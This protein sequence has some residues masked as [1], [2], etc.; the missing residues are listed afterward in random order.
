MPIDEKRRLA[1]DVID[2]S[3]TIEETERQVDALVEKLTKV[4][5]T[6]RNIS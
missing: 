1:D 5:A 4:A 6:Q 3:G 2:C